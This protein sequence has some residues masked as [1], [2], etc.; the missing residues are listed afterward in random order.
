MKCSEPQCWT[1]CPRTPCKKTENCP[2]CQTHCGDPVCKLDCPQP[3]DCSTMCEAPVCDWECTNPSACPEP[4]CELV[5]DN[6]KDCMNGGV[7]TKPLPPLKDGE[8]K[9]KSFSS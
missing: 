9:V 4:R 8:I 6:P 1:T 3:Q 2:E 5:C 7:S